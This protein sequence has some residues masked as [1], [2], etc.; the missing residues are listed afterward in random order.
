M[1]PSGI[2]TATV[3]P[4]SPV[5]VTV[6]VPSG[7][8]A[9]VAIGASGGVTSVTV[10]ANVL[11]VASVLDP[12]LAV[13]P[14]ST[15]WNVKLGV[16]GPA[17]GANTRLPRLVAGITLPAV[18]ATPESVSVPLAGSVVMMTLARELGGVSFGS[19]IPKS[20][21]EKI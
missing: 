17:A 21:T 16:A 8:G 11:G 15:S 3:D 2:V 19:V 5:P 1:V 18:M 7:F 6:S 20:A 10:I 9:E 14:L 12:P 4:G 13:P